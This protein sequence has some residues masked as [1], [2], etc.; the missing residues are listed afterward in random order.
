MI[1]TSR[2]FEI[3][4]ILLNKKNITAKEL[5]EYFEVSTRTIYR[6]IDTLNMAGIPIYTTQGKGGGIAILDNFVLNKTYLSKEEQIDLLSAI[7]ILKQL[8]KNID[9]H[10]LEKLNQ[11]FKSS[12]QDWIEI[13]FDRWGQKG[14]HHLFNL[15]KN[16][17]VHQQPISFQYYS[18]KG[19]QSS[20]EVEPVK[21]IF[22]HQDWYLFGYCS[23]R[24]DYRYFKISRMENTIILDKHFSKP[25][26]DIY[27]NKEIQPKTCNKTDFIKLTLKFSNEVAFRVYDDFDSQSITK[28]ND[29]SLLVHASFLEEQNQYLYGFLLSYE[30]KVTVIE[31]LKIKNELLSRLKKI[32]NNYSFD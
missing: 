16:A 4:Y 13:D 7:S 27:L 5:A 1:H 29:G 17:I 2:L 15:L 25:N 26:P 9:K 3:V 32:R 18:S 8:D 6:D 20:R 22:K 31:P 14:H 19:E 21:L 23:L 30:D 11:F 24:N 12:F 28:L 10:H